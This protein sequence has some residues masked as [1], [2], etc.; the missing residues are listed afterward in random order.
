VPSKVRGRDGG[1]GASKILTVRR[2]ILLEKLIMP[3]RIKK[4]HFMEFEVS[5]LCS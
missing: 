1:G 3:R 2:S 5:F 4:I